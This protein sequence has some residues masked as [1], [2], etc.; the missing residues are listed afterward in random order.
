MGEAGPNFF[1]VLPLI[2]L[3]EKY[4]S[5]QKEKSIHIIDPIFLQK[6]SFREHFRAKNPNFKILEWNEILQQ[7][8]NLVLRNF[9]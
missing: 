2:L 5:L 1:K 9:P 6:N 3:K 8:K 7:T 4:T